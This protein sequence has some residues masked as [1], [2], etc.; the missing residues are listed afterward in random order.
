MGR[1]DRPG[2]A[3][4]MGEGER[5]NI[6]PDSRSAFSTAHLRGA[7]YRERGLLTAEG[8]TV[9]N[10][11]EILEALRALWLPEAQAI[12]HCPGH[13]RADTPVARGTRRADS[14]AKEV[15]LTVT[16][17]LA[18][19]LPDPGAPTLPGTPNCTDAGLHWIKR[20]PVTQCSRGWWRAA[21]SSITLPEELGRR[22]LSRT[23]RS[24]H[25]GTRKME[26]LIRHAKITMKDSRA[27]SCHACQ[28]T[29]ATAHGSNP[30]TWLRGD[31]PG[32][33][34]EVEFTEVKP[35]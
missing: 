32:A 25:M 16:Q 29:N 5:I 33:Y 9:K 2:Q 26:D 1:T 12:T 22:V 7:P 6:H 17:V 35:G 19:T 27:K 34:W 31:R 4:T 24:T 30:G 3:L 8:K 10:R 28:L 15:A 20:L 11:T 21:D 23:H 13:Q 14:E 18:T